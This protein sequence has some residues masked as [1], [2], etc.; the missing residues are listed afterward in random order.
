MLAGVIVA[1]AGNTWRDRIK[2]RK[3][4]RQARDQAIAELL[5]SIV[6]LL[7][8][9]QAIRT[10]YHERGLCD[11]PGLR[12]HEARRRRRHQADRGVARPAHPDQASAEV[13]LLP[14][15][16][17]VPGWDVPAPPGQAAQMAAEIRQT[18]HERPELDPARLPRHPWRR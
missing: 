11:L 7:S 13:L 15:P 14:W 9:I 5:T 1:F 2:D 12:R 10:A 18:I 6:D 3:A 16:G 8:G 4:E 17:K